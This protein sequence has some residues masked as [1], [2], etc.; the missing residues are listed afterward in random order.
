MTELKI[1]IKRMLQMAFV[2]SIKCSLLSGTK[3]IRQT[4]PIINEKEDKRKGS[5]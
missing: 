5:R 1:A 2:L 4:R 3:G